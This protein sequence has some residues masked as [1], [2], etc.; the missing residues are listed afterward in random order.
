[1]CYQISLFSCYIR[2]VCWES[3]SSNYIY[4][5]VHHPEFYNEKPEIV[6][7]LF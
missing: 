6:L 5:F 1:M 2:K 3:I 4:D 7:S